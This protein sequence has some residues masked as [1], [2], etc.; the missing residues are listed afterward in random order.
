MAKKAAKAASPM[1]AMKVK[2]KKAMKEAMK[3]MKVKPKKAM[4]AVRIVRNPNGTIDIVEY[5]V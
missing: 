4:K 2:P 3:A 5:D 1:K